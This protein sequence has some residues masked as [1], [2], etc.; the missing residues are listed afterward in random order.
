M[1]VS[2]LRKALVGVPGDMFVSMSDCVIG[3]DF[4]VTLLTPGMENPVNWCTWE[5]VFNE[6]VGEVS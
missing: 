3:D 5:A 4:F 6:R 1:T 2:E